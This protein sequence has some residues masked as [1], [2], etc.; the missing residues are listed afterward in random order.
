MA[1]EPGDDDDAG[2]LSAALDAV[3]AEDLE[4]ARARL[5]DL[6]RTSPDSVAAWT[7]YGAVLGELGLEDQARCAL[8][9]ALALDPAAMEAAS[10]LGVLDREGGRLMEAEARFR[11]ILER[12]PGN[13]AAHYNLAHTLFLAAR[14]DEAAD[15]YRAGLR[16][17]EARTPNQ[18][19]RLAW[20]L[21]A[22]G[23]CAEAKRELDRSLGR[24]PPEEMEALRAEAAEVLPA[25]A[26]ARP[27][28]AGEVARLDRAL[29][30]TRGRR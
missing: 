9:S 29:I 8:E 15:V 23:R 10:N 17:D 6:V 3:R 18:N 19:A 20:S 5:A 2:L 30:A 4:M 12:E 7:N 1:R 26:A 27:D 16:R 13:L 25:I 14:F 24:L 21:L 22:A 28:L 11:A